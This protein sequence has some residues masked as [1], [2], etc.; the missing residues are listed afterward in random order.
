[1]YISAGGVIIAFCSLIVAI[2]AYRRTVKLD[3][4]E[5]T[6]NRKALIRA[7]GYKSGSA[8]KVNIWNDGQA[9]AKNIRFISDF[10]EN[11]GIM[12]L[13]EKGKFP[14]PLLNKG[15][16][17]EIRAALCESLNPNPLI[18]FIWDDEYKKNNEREQV[19]EF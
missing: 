6:Q 15:D 19:L 11:D 7:K 1:M 16:S 8:W 10:G 9:T 17:F 12:L 3:K 14:Y 4:K 13:P 18:K 2:S 5:N